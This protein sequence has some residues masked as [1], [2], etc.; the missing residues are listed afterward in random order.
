MKNV[1]IFIK[2]C[3]L[4]WR[5]TNKKK[6]NNNNDIKRL[7]TVK[8]LQVTFETNEQQKKIQS[9]LNNR[10][11]IM[12][13][14]TAFVSNSNNNTLTIGWIAVWKISNRDYFH[15]CR[16]G[17]WYSCAQVIFLTEEIWLPFGTNGFLKAKKVQNQY[18]IVATLANGNGD[19]GLHTEVLRAFW[20]NAMQY[21]SYLNKS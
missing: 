18:S 13:L 4:S 8:V 2:V 15:L 9:T 12:P 20:L 7:K 14:K 6:K 3:K 21:I 11:F 19:N 1:V 17:S 5:I 10:N 16:L